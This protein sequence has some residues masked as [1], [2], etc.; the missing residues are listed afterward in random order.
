MLL[1]LADSLELLRLDLA[2]GE[3]HRCQVGRR[4]LGLGQEPLLQ[5]NLSDRR[6]SMIA[7]QFFRLVTLSVCLWRG[8]GGEGGEVIAVEI[9]RDLDVH[10]VAS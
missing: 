7:F 3:M 1:G 4:I 6:V 9:V 10:N 2:V 5:R 8:G